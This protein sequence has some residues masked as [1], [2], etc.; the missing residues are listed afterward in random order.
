MVYPFL[1]GYTFL[2]LSPILATYLCLANMWDSD[3]VEINRHTMDLVPDCMWRYST[4]VLYF[5]SSYTCRGAF[6]FMNQ[7]SILKSVIDLIGIGLLALFLYL[8]L[9]FRNSPISFMNP[10]F[11]ILSENDWKAA[12]PNVLDWTKYPERFVSEDKFSEVAYYSQFYL[13]DYSQMFPNPYV[14]TRIEPTNFSSDQ[15]VIRYSETDYALAAL[16]NNYEEHLSSL[17]PYQY[18]ITDIPGLDFSS[19]AD[20]HYI[21]CEQISAD[22]KA[23]FDAVEVDACFYWAAYGRYFSRIRFHMWPFVGSGRQFSVELFN[24]ILNR[25]DNKLANV[26]K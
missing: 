4:R 8:S 22:D 19:K 14:P 20:A 18:L 11:P 13:D 9:A 10:G 24:D 26:R 12:S 1:S 23:T 16:Q 15:I 5:A 25:A 7:N 6:Y 3:L 17:K 2:Y 21:W